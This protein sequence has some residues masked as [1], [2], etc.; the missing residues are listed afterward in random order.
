M[1]MQPIISSIYLFSYRP[2]TDSNVLRLI[3]RNEIEYL[4]GGIFLV[5]RKG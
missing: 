3:T 2:S 4:P 5:M 1:R